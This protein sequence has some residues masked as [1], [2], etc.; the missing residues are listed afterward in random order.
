MDVD[1]DN[2]AVQQQRSSRCPAEGA[3]EDSSPCPMVA[4]LVDVRAL[5][6][7][8]VLLFGSR[9]LFAASTNVTTPIEPDF[10]CK[11]AAW[12]RWE[13]TRLMMTRRRQ[14]LRLGTTDVETDRV[15]A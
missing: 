8:G 13:K 7:D 3:G 6:E 4:R 14:Q 2:G 1:D 12:L 15:W 5:D 10:P 9:G 11:A